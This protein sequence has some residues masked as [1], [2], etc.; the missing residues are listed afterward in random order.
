MLQTK[1]GGNSQEEIV[2]EYKKVCNSMPIK[3]A[4]T[5]GM[6]L[7]KAMN[8]QQGRVMYPMYSGE[9]DDYVIVT[10]PIGNRGDSKGIATC[11]CWIDQ[12]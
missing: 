11:S 7:V 10:E 2:N 8:I 6:Y 4:I 12:V 9:T 1:W 3:D 5:E